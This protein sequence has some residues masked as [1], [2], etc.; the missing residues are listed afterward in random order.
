[1]V[2][3]YCCISRPIVDSYYFFCYS[4]PCLDSGVFYI[5]YMVADDVYFV[6]AKTEHN[7]GSSPVSY[8]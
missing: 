3:L 2:G 4:F 8:R 6:N 7:E 5:V 1:M